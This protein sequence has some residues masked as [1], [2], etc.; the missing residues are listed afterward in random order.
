MAILQEN[1]IYDK[2]YRMAFL[3]LGNYHDAWDLT[4]EVFFALEKGRKKWEEAENKW[5]WACGVFHRQRKKFFRKQKECSVVSLVE[6]SHNEEPEHRI[7]IQEQLHKTFEVIKTLNVDQKEALLLFSLEKLS[8]K[9]IALL[10]SASI[11]TVKWRIFEARRK[12][13]GLVLEK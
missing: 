3:M 1:E 9:E 4:Q 7:I 2:I 10:Q 6:N 11:G 12:I 8:I 5:A 13:S